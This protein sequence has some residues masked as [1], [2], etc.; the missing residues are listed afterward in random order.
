MT[1]FELLKE[2]STKSKE[3]VETCLSILMQAGKIDF[4][5]LQGAYVKY[6]EEKKEEN[7]NKLIEAETCILESFLYDEIPVSNKEA[8][9]SAQ[10]RLY[11]LNQG[12]RFQM[13]SL[14]EKF[15]YDEERAKTYNHEED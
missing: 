15:G 3:E 8:E 2:L 10:R 14:N 9:I 7:L 6:L 11:F 1:T 5:R 4:L 12:R 13:K